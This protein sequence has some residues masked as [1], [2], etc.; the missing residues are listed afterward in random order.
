MRRGGEGWEAY[1]LA[2]DGGIR[3]FVNVVRSS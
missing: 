3:F 2:Q 1:I